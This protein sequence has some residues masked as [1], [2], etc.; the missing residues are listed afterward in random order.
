MEQDTKN[1]L[2]GNKDKDVITF[3]IGNNVSEQD[4]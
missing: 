1:M 2:Q 3:L 4:L